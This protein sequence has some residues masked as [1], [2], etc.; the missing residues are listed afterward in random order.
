MDIK[1]QEWYLETITTTQIMP[2]T[3]IIIGSYKITTALTSDGNNHTGSCKQQYDNSGSYSVKWLGF[4]VFGWG[5][6]VNGR[7]RWPGNN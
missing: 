6:H 3:K 4:L 1:K 7:V 2:T 5:G